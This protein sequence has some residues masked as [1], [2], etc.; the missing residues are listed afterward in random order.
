MPTVRSLARRFGV[1]AFTA[2]PYPHLTFDVRGGPLAGRPLDG[3]VRCNASA[4][5][6]K[7]RLCQGLARKRRPRNQGEGRCNLLHLEGDS[8]APTLDVP[9]AQPA[10][11]VTEDA[12]KAGKLDAPTRHEHPGLGSPRRR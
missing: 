1:K 9:P 10:P 8:D 11:S 4:P 5:T 6:V 12:E 2:C 7:V 3:G